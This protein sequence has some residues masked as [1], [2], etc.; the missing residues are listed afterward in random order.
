MRE[1][2]IFSILESVFWM[3][4]GEEKN[5]TS[6]Y[7]DIIIYDFYQEDN[8]QRKGLWQGGGI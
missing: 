2:Q 7:A 6:K 5:K 4:P 1:A 8:K 3:E